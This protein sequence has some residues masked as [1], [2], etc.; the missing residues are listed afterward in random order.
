VTRA[1]LGAAALQ[2]HLQE[3]GEA[4][5]SGAMRWG[6]VEHF[7]TWLARVEREKNRDKKAIGAALDRMAL[8]VQSADEPAATGVTLS[9]LHGVK[10]LEFEVVFLIGCVEGQLPH[11]RTL[12]PKLTEVVTTEI[13]EERRLF[14]VGVTRARERLYLTRFRRR[15]LR[16]KV[17]EAIASRFL[18][19]LPAEHLE[20]YERP[21]K[22][23][24]SFDEISE[25]ARSF[26]ESRRAKSAG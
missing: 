26:L 25:I 21:E 14:Y 15:S 8:G 4:G 12:D 11:S 6:N 13:D 22:Q 17:V 18:E 3:P 10:G 24:M 7:L 16:G 1:L 9:T 5:E 20:T 2:D 23:E 19:G